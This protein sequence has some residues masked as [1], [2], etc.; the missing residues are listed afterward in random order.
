MYVCIWSFHP[1]FIKGYSI[2]FT[3]LRK[4]HFD[5]QKLALY[6]VGVAFILYGIDKVFDFLPLSDS[7]KL[8]KIM[9]GIGVLDIGIGIIFTEIK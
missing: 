8:A 1:S 2:E 6:S 3:R 9:L 4:M 7:I 5:T